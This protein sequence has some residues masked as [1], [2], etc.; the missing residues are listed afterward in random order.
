MLS[1]NTVLEKA[2]LGTLATT[3]D[4]AT[5]GP[6]GEVGLGG[7]AEIAGNFSAYATASYQ[8]GFDGGV[9][10]F[11]GSIGLRFNP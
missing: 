5:S 10:T 9:R 1:G 6:W 4:T 2:D 11:G 8:K 3:T 7:N